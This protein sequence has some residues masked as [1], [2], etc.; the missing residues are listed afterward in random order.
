MK[1]EAPGT[2]LKKL[3]SAVSKKLIKNCI[4]IAVFRA[5]AII[6]FTRTISVTT[7]QN[8]HVCHVSDTHIHDGLKCKLSKFFHFNL[9]KASFILFFGQY[10]PFQQNDIILFCHV[11]KNVTKKSFTSYKPHIISKCQEK[12]FTSSNSDYQL[13]N[14]C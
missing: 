13:Y 3:I 14:F 11:Q 6:L 9:F 4:D 10:F 5:T 1:F 7:L 12:F 2:N 8:F